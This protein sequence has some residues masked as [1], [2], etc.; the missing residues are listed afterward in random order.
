MQKGNINTT[1]NLLTNIISHGIFK[2]DQEIIYL[3][4]FK[5]S[6]KNYASENTLINGPIKKVHPIL[7]E[8]INEELI[9]RA[10]IETKGGDSGPSSMDANEYQRILTSNSSV[11]A[12]SSLLKVFPKTFK[13]ICTGLIKT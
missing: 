6:Q 1:L 5:D 11:T 13:K 8:S 9:R 10:A 2:L 4:D 3:L 7:L 12:N